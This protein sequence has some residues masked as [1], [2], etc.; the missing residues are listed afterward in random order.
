MSSKKLKRSLSESDITLENN[1]PLARKK[2]KVPREDFAKRLTVAECSRFLGDSWNSSAGKFSNL[3]GQE[4]AGKVIQEEL[5]AF[6][7]NDVRTRSAFGSRDLPTSEAGSSS[8]LVHVHCSIDTVL[9]G[10]SAP[11]TDDSAL[12]FNVYLVMPISVMNGLFNENSQSSEAQLQ[13]LLTSVSRLLSSSILKVVEEG[14]ST[15]VGASLRSREASVSALWLL[16]RRLVLEM[17]CLSAHGEPQQALIIGSDGHG[18]ALNRKFHVKRRSGIAAHKEQLRS[19]LQAACVASP[20]DPPLTPS[21]GLESLGQN[22]I[23]ESTQAQLRSRLTELLALESEV[24]AS[25]RGFFE[26]LLYMC[27]QTAD[28]EGASDQ[29]NREELIT[30][31]LNVVLRNLGSGAGLPVV[32]REIFLRILEGDLNTQLPLFGAPFQAKPK[33]LATQEQIDAHIPSFR[34]PGKSGSDSTRSAPW[35]RPLAIAKSVFQTFVGQSTRTNSSVEQFLSSAL[36][37]TAEECAICGQKYDKD[38][39]LRLLPC[40]HAYHAECIDSWL[41]KYVNECCLCRRKPV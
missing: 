24:P 30:H 26:D 11:S 4:H 7:I 39:K 27:I 37:S 36:G 8:T 18:T 10:G 1:E 9:S 22:P 2:L 5:A 31:R 41:R 15:R 14:L 6:L 40:N 19:V 35:F 12:Y 28:T 20:A 34:Y 13:V 3:S 16:T 23:W 38:Q 21:S 25:E 29:V 33:I 32:F 17:T